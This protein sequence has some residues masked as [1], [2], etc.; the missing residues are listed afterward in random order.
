MQGP[1]RGGG[2]QPGVRQAL[3]CC[4][5][6]LGLQLQQLPHQVLGRLRDAVPLLG[7]PQ[8]SASACGA[9]RFTGS[10]LPAP[11]KVHS[12]PCSAVSQA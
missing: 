7:Q 12:S 10:C 2:V 9:A 6:L 11:S 1:A 5:A 4:E 8:L 3:L